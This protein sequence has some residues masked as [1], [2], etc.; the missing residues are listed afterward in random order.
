[1][2]WCNKVSATYPRITLALNAFV[3][4]TMYSGMPLTETVWI[5][6]LRCEHVILFM[7][8]NFLKSW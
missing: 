3:I 7:T 2:F 8:Q 1:M 6:N 5:L 4:M